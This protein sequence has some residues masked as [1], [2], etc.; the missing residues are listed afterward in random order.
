MEP[1]T[2]HVYQVFVP[3]LW[4][5]IEKSLKGSFEDRFSD[6]TIHRQI[7]GAGEYQAVNDMRQSVQVDLDLKTCFVVDG[8]VTDDNNLY[9]KADKKL[10]YPSYTLPRV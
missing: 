10:R 1:F 3:I 2:I 4:K 5:Q 9:L 6:I 7:I 8:K